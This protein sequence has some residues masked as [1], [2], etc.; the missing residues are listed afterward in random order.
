MTRLSWNRP[1]WT[2]TEQRRWTETAT[3][4]ADVQRLL[5][6]MEVLKGEGVL[7]YEQVSKAEGVLIDITYSATDSIKGARDL[8][9]AVLGRD[10]LARGLEHEGVE[11]VDKSANSV[12]VMEQK[13]LQEIL[14]WKQDLLFASVFAVPLFVVS[15]VLGMLLPR[16]STVHHA[17]HSVAFLNLLW[18]EVVTLVLAT[19]V[20]FVSGRRFYKDAYFAVVKNRSV[21]GMSTLVALSTSAAY[22]YSVFAVLYNAVSDPSHRF[23]QF[24]ESSSMLILFVLLGKYL[25]AI[26]KA[27]TSKA[28]THLAQLT[29]PVARVLVSDSDNTD[30][31]QQNEVLVA[32]ELVQPDDLILLK[33]ADK[34]PVDCEVVRGETS[35][36][37]SMLTGEALPVKKAVGDSVFAGSVNFDGAVVCKVTKVGHQT[38]LSQIT[39]LV[40][41]AQFSKPAIQ[42]FAD[43]VSNLFVPAV[44]L[45]SV[46]TFVVWIVVL[47]SKAFDDVIDTWPFR[48]VHGMGDFTFALLFA[49][50]VLV[51]ACPCAL[52]LATPTAVMVATGVGAK[53]GILIKSG[54]VLETAH[55]LTSVVFDKTGTL[56]KGEPSVTDIILLRLEDPSDDLDCQSMAN[57]TRLGKQKLMWFVACAEAGSE[58]PLGKAILARAIEMH[59]ESQLLED[60]SLRMTPLSTTPPK[61]FKNHPGFGI[62]C[63]VADVQVVVGN[64]KC[65]DLMGVECVDEQELKLAVQ[66][67]EA[68]GKTAVHV[69]IDGKVAGLLGVKDVPRDDAAITVAALQAI[70]IKVY[71][72]TGDNITTAHVIAGDLGIP[73]S[74]VIAG[75]VPE[76]KA[77]VVQSFKNL[78][79]RRGREEVVAMIGDGV[80]DAPALAIGESVQLLIFVCKPISSRL[81]RKH[82]PVDPCLRKPIH[83]FAMLSKT[84][85]NMCDSADLGISVQSGSDIAIEAADMILLSN[86]LQDL[87]AA[88][89]LSRTTYRRIQMN[90]FWALLFNSLGIPIAAGLLYPVLFMAL[91]PWLAAAAM[92]ASSVLVCLSSLTLKYYRPPT[93]GGLQYGRIRRKGKLGLERLSVF[94]LFSGTSNVEN[95]QVNIGCGMIGGGECTCT[96]ESCRCVNC[97]T[98]RQLRDVVVG[99]SLNQVAS[100]NNLFDKMRGCAT[101]YGGECNCGVACKCSH[102]K[103]LRQPLLETTLT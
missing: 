41:D 49:I 44:L 19:P 42:K 61:D 76:Q 16:D 12:A 97:E 83:V 11:V 53:L 54:T 65:L 71:M 87:I 103:A 26:A 90:L 34:V 36:D 17:L 27:N 47:Q 50:S 70:G 5:D 96:P 88:I 21:G 39:K 29:P 69:A 58:H 3:L 37:E 4:D 72:L 24:F 13:R 1:R 73:A 35:I 57:A 93:I 85:L 81:A 51:I 28:L 56:T 99:P 95:Y 98:H 59:D 7:Q 38:T 25:E 2:E 67:L 20:Q 75:V 43:R 94:G 18:I 63:E 60:P 78:K 101:Q 15:M 80:N 79:S 92:A 48:T 64:R 9:S 46:T 22:F 8:L 62:A 6:A 91:P 31:S 55:K 66:F 45:I 89:D 84:P 52:G 40:E 23:M 33:S 68:Q 14:S 74:N 100:D 82:L 32:V 10:V 86:K 77:E 102:P 30:D